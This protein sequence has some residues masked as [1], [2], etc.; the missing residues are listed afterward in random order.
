MKMNRDLSRSTFVCLDDI[1]GEM[2]LH[3]Y[4]IYNPTKDPV[5]VRIDTLY[6][7]IKERFGIELSSDDVI[8]LVKYDVTNLNEFVADLRSVVKH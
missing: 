3:N 1:S 4:V 8:R 7:R 5:H 6:D 2:E